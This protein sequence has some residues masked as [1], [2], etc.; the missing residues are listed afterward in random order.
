LL[1]V[2]AVPG[3]YVAD[4]LGLVLV[5]LSKEV[6]HGVGVLRE[7]FGIGVTAELCLFERFCEERYESV[8]VLFLA[9]SRLADGLASVR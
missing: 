5:E 2:G 7:E 4:V 8:D 6:S 1:A 3:C 9:W